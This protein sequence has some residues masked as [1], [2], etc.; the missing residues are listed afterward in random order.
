M[1]RSEDAATHL[2]TFSQCRVNTS[3][4]KSNIFTHHIEY[5][6]GGAS[7]GC[8]SPLPAEGLGRSKDEGNDGGPSESTPASSTKVNPQPARPTSKLR[9]GFRKI[10]PF[11]R[12]KTDTPT[13]GIAA[14]GL[15]SGAGRSSPSGSTDAPQMPRQS[16]GT[17]RASPKASPK[18]R[19]S[20]G[21]TSPLPRRPAQQKGATLK[22]PSRPPEAD[23]PAAVPPAAM[24]PAVMPPA[25]IPPAAPSGFYSH[26][27][28]P[29]TAGGDS[30]GPRPR[31]N[32]S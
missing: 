4:D 11:R 20:S 28:H 7:F 9:N 6:V 5:T 17:V 21:S 10:S 25:A 30:S 32:R 22:Q 27:R 14:S 8:S 23:R 2:V 15:P 1:F 24:P 12:P 16:S 3:S 19:P 29:V 26:G 13:G 18:H 31:A